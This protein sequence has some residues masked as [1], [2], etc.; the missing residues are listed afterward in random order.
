MPSLYHTKS[1]LKQHRLAP[2]KKLGQN[3]LVQQRIADNII[4]LADINSD[5]TVIEIGVG[6]G[7]L[8]RPLSRKAGQIIGIEID[9]GIIR[10]HEEKN[11]LPDN[12]TLIHQDVLKTDFSVLAEDTG[13]PVK[14]VANLPYSISNPFIFKMLENPGAVEWAILMLQKEVAQR[15]V[16]QP[17]TKAYGI[18]SVLL[19]CRASVETLMNVGPGNFHPQP[20]VDSQ[21][22]RIRFLPVPERAVSLPDFDYKLLERVVKAGFQQ[23]RKTLL[24]SLAAAAIIDVEKEILAGLIEQAGISTRRRCETL[25]LD[26]FVL[27]TNILAAYG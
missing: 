21:V 11:E 19:A 24:N 8:T 23:R 26:D 25:S 2:H 6:L 18:L 9:A 27:L 22:V 7:A 1:T 5:D 12:V 17:G 4:G 20:K 13:K 14:I 10:M 3:F 16:A 15:L